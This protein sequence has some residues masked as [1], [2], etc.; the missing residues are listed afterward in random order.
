ML[1]ST[2]TRYASTLLQCCFGFS[3]LSVS[4]QEQRLTEFSHHSPVPHPARANCATAATVP[5]SSSGPA[6]ATSTH[7]QPG[8]R[9]PPLPFLLLETEHPNPNPNVS[10][11]YSEV[12]SG[13][14]TKFI[15]A[16]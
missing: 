15:H 3:L 14:I 6:P 12:G 1:T 10:Y 9:T 8:I 13:L 4:A 16:F 7:H 2:A 11:L 5:R